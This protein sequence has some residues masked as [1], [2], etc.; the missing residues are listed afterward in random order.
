LKVI[1]TLQIIFEHVNIILYVVV[2]YL[3]LASSRPR[4][5]AHIL[6]F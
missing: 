5:A 6:A 2:N 3:A 1:F 4:K